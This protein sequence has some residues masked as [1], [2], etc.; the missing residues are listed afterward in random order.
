MEQPQ[1]KGISEAQKRAIKKYYEKNREK[2]NELSRIRYEKK[3]LLKK[4]GMLKKI[5][6]E[7]KK[8]LL[9]ELEEERKL[10]Y[11]NTYITGILCKGCANYLPPMT[12]NEHLDPNNPKNKCK[13]CNNND[14]PPSA[15][16]QIQEEIKT[17]F[18][19]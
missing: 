6:E 5:S 12:M 8:N 3:A 19:E 2:V 14:A 10:I 4:E 1:K 7:K 18:F 13:N 17:C 15:P 11:A 9:V 16:A